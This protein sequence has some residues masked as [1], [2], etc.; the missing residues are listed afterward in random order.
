MCRLSRCE[1]WL[2]WV[3][4]IPTSCSPV[5]VLYYYYYHNK[6]GNIKTYFL[7]KDDGSHTA[8]HILS[9][10]GTELAGAGIAD[11]ISH[12]SLQFVAVCITRRRRA[13]QCAAVLVSPPWL[14]LCCRPWRDWDWTQRSVLAV[15]S[16]C[17]GVRRP[18]IVPHSAP[19]PAETSHRGRGSR[20]TW[21]QAGGGHGTSVCDGIG[22]T[23]WCTRE[24]R[25]GNNHINYERRRNSNCMAMTIWTFLPLPDEK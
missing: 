4:S 11:L 15:V 17:A 21:P 8:A 19:L 7:H 13:G 20:D 3:A 2:E 18:R 16:L 5:S 24:N 25:D 14:R 22:G 1:V 9:S 12:H 10:Q 23:T 6:T